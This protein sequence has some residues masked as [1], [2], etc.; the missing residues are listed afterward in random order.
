MTTTTEDQVTLLAED[1][2]P[3][4]AAPRMTVHTEDTAVRVAPWAL[5]PWMVEQVDGLIAAG[6]LNEDPTG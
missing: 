6:H 1:G 2:T 4:G 5:S 3:I